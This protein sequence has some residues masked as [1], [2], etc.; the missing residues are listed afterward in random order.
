M[1]RLF[2]SEPGEQQLCSDASQL[3]DRL[4]DNRDRRMKDIGHIKI[5]ETG[6]CRA[7]GNLYSQ[8]RKRMQQMTHCKVITREKSSGRLRTFHQ[9]AQD[10]A[11]LLSGRALEVALWN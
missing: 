9:G 2:F 7:P 6:H 1:R 11:G 8:F 3:I 10:G 5:V 4:T